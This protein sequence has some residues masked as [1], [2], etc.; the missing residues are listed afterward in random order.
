MSD[1]KMSNYELNEILFDAKK[2]IEKITYGEDISKL[3][4]NMKQL[5]ETLDYIIQR[6]NDLLFPSDKEFYDKF[7]EANI[8][9]KT[10]MSNALL[11]SGIKDKIKELDTAYNNEKIEEKKNQDIKQKRI[12]EKFWRPHYNNQTK[13]IVFF[14]FYYDTDGYLVQ[15]G[16]DG[17]REKKDIRL[18][19]MDIKSR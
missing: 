18:A 6:K 4:F 16:N 7:V 14:D 17:I 19:D 13:A 15:I 5:C 1:F 2:Y 10:A 9:L 12:I 11:N 3:W 8:K